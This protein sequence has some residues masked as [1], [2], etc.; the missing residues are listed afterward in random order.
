MDCN[1][2]LGQNA[3][4]RN[5]A[6]RGTVRRAG[7]LARSRWTIEHVGLAKRSDASLNSLVHSF[8]QR[9]ISHF[10]VAF[11]FMPIQ[12]GVPHQRLVATWTFF[13]GAQC[14]PR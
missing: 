3:L 4:L 6:D 1:E 2:F 10:R 9:F 8:Q 12:Q 14:D 11:A 13:I 5:V 7:G